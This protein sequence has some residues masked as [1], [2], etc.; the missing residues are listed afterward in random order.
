MGNKYS[1]S[2]DIEAHILKYTANSAVDILLKYHNINVFHNILSDST[3]KS[4]CKKVAWTCV[5]DTLA[6][7]CVYHLD[8]SAKFSY[9]KFIPPIETIQCYPNLVSLRLNAQKLHHGPRLFENLTKLANLRSLALSFTDITNKDLENVVLSS[10]K[11][12]QI[13]ETPIDNIVQIAKTFPNLEY[14]KV[15][16]DDFDFPSHTEHHFY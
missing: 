16:D 13:V 1:L 7:F 9:D 5:P 10:V 4:L 3:I 14:L 8:W 6:P 2:S 12:L 11:T 15:S